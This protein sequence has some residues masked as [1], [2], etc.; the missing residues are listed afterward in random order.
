M[1]LARLCRSDVPHPLQ[2]YVPA[3]HFH[4]RSQY[5]LSYGQSRVKTKRRGDRQRKALT[6]EM[7]QLKLPKCAC[8]FSILSLSFPWSIFVVISSPILLPGPYHSL[9]RV[10][11]RPTCRFL[12][13]HV[14][15]RE[16]LKTAKFFLRQAGLLDGVF[17]SLSVL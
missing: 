11:E 9:D 4:H 13:R 3:N 16:Q 14:R 7:V 15:C 6:H 2:R 5:M 17:G 12:V 10:G 8:L 1:S